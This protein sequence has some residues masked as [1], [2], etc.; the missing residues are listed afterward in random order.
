MD[1]IITAIPIVFLFLCCCAQAQSSKKALFII[2]HE[3]FRDEELFVPKSVLEKDGYQVIIAS[4]S[5]GKAKGALGGVAKPDILLKDANVSE[6]RIIVFVGGAG[7]SEYWDDPLAH[8]ISREA[9]KQGKIL[10]AICI[11]PVTLANAGVLTGKKAT[12]FGSET[13]RLKSKGAVCTGKNVESDGNIVTASGPQA[14]EAFGEALIRLD[15]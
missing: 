13:A 8:N 1:K 4:S 11:A 10:G 2:A 6:Y 15:K 12:V 7:A 14:A 9:V 3:N 5:T